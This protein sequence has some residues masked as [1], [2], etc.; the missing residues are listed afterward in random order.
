[1]DRDPYECLASLL[2]LLTPQDVAE[3]TAVAD[4]LV[5]RRIMHH[6]GPASSGQNG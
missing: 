3:L 2:W 6:F 4:S 1:M 5:E